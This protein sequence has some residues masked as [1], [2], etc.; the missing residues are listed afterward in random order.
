MVIGC[1]SKAPVKSEAETVLPEEST[2]G[3]KTIYEIGLSEDETAALVTIYGNEPL[4]YTAVKMQFPLGVVLYFRDTALQDIEETYVTESALIKSIETSELDGETRS[5]RIEIRLNEDVPYDVGREEN[6]I[7]ARFGKPAAELGEAGKPEEAVEAAQKIEL[8]PQI[9][10]DEAAQP[11]A[12]VSA[13]APGAVATATGGP[14]S[15]EEVKAAGWVDRIDFEIMKEGKSRVIVGTT[16]KVRYETEKPSDKRLLLKLYG[17]R[18]PR[19]QRR[20][21]ITTRFKSAVDYVI[22]V[23]T[24]QMGDTAVIAIQL[25]EA[26]DYTVE[27]QDNVCFVEFERTK[28]PPKPMPKIDK[29]KWLQAMM[30]AE[31]VVL[32]EEE[33]IVK[34]AAE[35]LPEEYVET[36]EGK[37]YTGQKI[38]LD[39]QNADIHDIFRILH[40]VS[41]DNFVVGEVV[42]GKVT[43][44][45]D[46]VPWDQV[47]D[48]VLKMNKLGTI[49]EGNVVRIA[50]LSGLEA[51]QVALRQ[52]LAAQRAKKDEEP[53]V[54]RFF[55]ISYADAMVLSASGGNVYSVLTKRG[56]ATHD[57][58]TN[59]LIIND[60]EGVM[61]KV[62]KLVERLD[63]PTPQVMISARIVEADK[64]FTR[65]LGVQWGGDVDINNPGEDRMQIFGGQ[66]LSTTGPNYAV[67][68]PPSFHSSAIG[69][70]FGK[71]SGIPFNIDLRLLAMET[72]GKGRTISAPKI[73]TLDNK[74]A[75]IEQGVEIPYQVID[76]GS[77]TIK[78]AKAV[79]KLSVTPHISADN[80]INL[81]IKATKDAP[82]WT[83]AVGGT[84]AIDK[85]EAKTELLVN[86]GETVV[87]GGILTDTDAW[88]ESS[89]PFLSKIPVLGWLFRSKIKTLSKEEILIF[90]T[91]KII[92]LAGA[93]QEVS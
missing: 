21:L 32:R 75:Y 89:V 52:K 36:E 1:A 19:F 63:I 73:V 79:L 37:L 11:V 3:G 85:K 92:R 80:R 87:I 38:S 44:K 12:A 60:I 13:E 14:T 18:I 58:R 30:E 86:D 35:V 59:M 62:K 4:T 55:E 5:S 76:D 66:T 69:M 6:Q 65:D 25:R 16:R 74:E 41:G 90:I 81:K 53:L 88:T 93:T 23:Q 50:T 33:A 71:L 9:V 48:L 83:N 39:F 49:K 91:P 29:P 2:F 51:E 26:V 54:T 46:N 68:L 61:D 57:I 43:L 82:D 31:E 72:R 15:A 27:Q 64:T 78:W 22:P 17:T 10:I 24:P 45:L 84:P 70:T 40:E 67:N 34:E 42:R 47:L 8:E 20:P 56:K 28:V 7:V 77:V